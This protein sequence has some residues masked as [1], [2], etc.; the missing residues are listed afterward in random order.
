M[1]MKAPGFTAIAVLTLALGIGAN[2][3]IFSVVNAALI[4]PLP[5]HDPN[6]LV[7][8]HERNAQQPQVSVAYPN[9]VDWRAQNQVFEQ[10]AVYRGMRFN[11]AGADRPESVSGAMISANFLTTLGARPILGRDLIP[12]E[13]QPGTSPAV[14]ISHELW[15]GRFAANPAAIGSSITLDGRPF[16]IA[17]ILPPRF[18]VGGPVQVLVPLGPWVN[19]LN[20]RGSHSDTVVIARLKPE[21]TVER[22]RA[23]MN[24]IARRLEQQYPL[25]NS[26]YS[27]VIGS[28]RDEF[29]GDFRPA[30]LVLFAAVGLVLLI[31]CANVANLLLV[32]A[33]GRGNEMAIRAALGA[34]RLRVIRQMLTESLILAISGGSLGLLFGVWALDGLVALIPEDLRAGLVINIDPWVLSFTAAVALATAVLS[35]LAPALQAPYSD[36]NAA[37]KEGGRNTSQGA[38]HKRLRA[39]LAASEIALAVV[40]LV[41]AGLLI[42]SLRQ[43]LKVDPGFNPQNVLAMGVSLPE[44]QYPKPEQVRA[45]CREVLGRIQRLPGVSLAAIG[46]ELPMSGSHT[47]S[48]ITIEGQPLPA[49]GYFPHPDFHFISPDYFRVMGI[50]LLR[51]RVFLESDN[52]KAPVAVLISQGLARRYWPGGDAVGKRLLRG[53]YSKDNNKWL[54]IVGVVGDTKQY[55]LGNETRMEVYLSYLQDPPGDMRFVVRSDSDP[56]TLTAAIK[57]EI[58]AVDRGE[59][60]DAVT[61]QQLVTSSTGGRRSTVMLLSVFA[62]L[63]LVLAGVGIY[64]VIAYSV[65]QRTQEIGI[66]MALG[67]GRG[68]VVKMVVRQ[69]MTLTFIGVAAGLTAALVLTRLMASLLFHIG[70]T[71]PLTYIAVSLILSAVALVASY[72]PARRATRVDPIAALRYE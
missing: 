61:M 23:E 54:D 9:F 21:A 18:Q 49:V 4:R 62:A 67:A 39:T 25:T 29:T 57:N 12:E 44:Q 27:V 66:R 10:M 70:S 34:G 16:T 33:A 43:L 28:L 15:Q 41:G 2:T 45:F 14:L 47:R 48:D 65:S 22:A 3:A 58:W 31:A 50:P 19:E 64:S 56:T 7:V 11:L 72:V 42:R 24:T 1:L 30:V 13:D 5:F 26:T 40:L 71:D 37:L 36:L 38:G 60:A 46:T 63:A 55:G 17:G 68:D 35:G 6:R 20:D 51:G 53:R 69:G 32:R 59:P 8:L 52:E